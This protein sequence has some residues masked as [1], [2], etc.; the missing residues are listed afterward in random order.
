MSLVPDYFDVLSIN[1]KNEKV[2]IIQSLIGTDCLGT[3]FE[4]GTAQLYFN[5]GNKDD[6]ELRLQNINADVNFNWKWNKQPKED[7]HLAWQDNFTP[8]I[9]EKKLAIIP[10]WENDTSSN[11]VI[12]IK[13]GMAFG[14]GH[15]ETTWLM[16]NQ[17]LKHIKPGMSILDLGAGSGILS[18]AAIKLG[19]KK[20]DA[21]EFDSDCE[22]NFNENLQLNSIEKNIH[23]YNDDV[24][25]WKDFNYNIIINICENNIIIKIFP[26][27]DIIIVIMNIFFNAIQL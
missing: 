24:L 23:Y 4:N 19:A 10:N 21:V 27:E 17:I 6:I 14:T 8:V 11:I 2:D 25:T 20:V 15:H 3:Y 16:L 18:I 1:E 9:I 13:P 26:S 5:G 22:P 12:K 7:W